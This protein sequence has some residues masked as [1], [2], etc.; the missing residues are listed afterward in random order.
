MIDLPFALCC[1]QCCSQ[2][3][4]MSCTRITDRYSHPQAMLQH[5]TRG[6]GSTHHDNFCIQQHAAGS[7]LRKTQGLHPVLRCQSCA[8]PTYHAA[9]CHMLCEVLA[10]T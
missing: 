4:D 1:N 6:S 3:V 9:L 8:M 2:S 7:V 10:P 5:I